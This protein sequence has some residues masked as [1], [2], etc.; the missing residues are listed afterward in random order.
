MIA[1][2]SDSFAAKCGSPGEAR[3]AKSSVLAGVSG[4]GPPKKAAGPVTG[5]AEP[6]RAGGGWAKGHTQA[7]PMTPWQRPCHWHSVA[8]S[9]VTPG[10]RNGTAPRPREPGA[11]PC[12]RRARANS[13]PQPPPPRPARG[14][15]SD[16]ETDRDGP[17]R[18]PSARRA[19]PQR[20]RPRR[21][22]RLSCDPGPDHHTS[23]MMR[24]ARAMI[25]PWL[26]L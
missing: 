21:R 1:P 24:R 23:I 7:V 2:G 3:A 10:T 22:P 9:T 5:R 26:A 6:G 18:P 13:E 15:K 25:M 20:L 11:R 17:R 4:P 12:R 14:P 16:S 19:V 8:Q